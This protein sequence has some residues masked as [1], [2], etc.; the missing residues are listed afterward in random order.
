[1]ISFG[2]VNVE[3][4]VF[5]EIKA[6]LE[7]DATFFIEKS[8]SS[9]VI[10]SKTL[11]DSIKAPIEKGSKLGEIIFSVDDEVVKTVNIVAAEPVKKLNIINMTTNLYSNW[12]KLLR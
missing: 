10:Q 11:P 7:E 5:S 4:G 1:M 9:N 2:I 12:F 3:K 6:I 8:K